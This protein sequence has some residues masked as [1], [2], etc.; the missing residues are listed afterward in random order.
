M[1]GVQLELGKRINAIRHNPNKKLTILMPELLKMKSGI[2][3][4]MAVSDPLEGIVDFFNAVNPVFDRVREITETIDAFDAANYGDRHKQLLKQLT[5]LRTHVRNAG[6]DRSGMNRTKTGELT[7]AHT[8]FL[9]DIW[10]LFT[11]TAFYWK[12][13][14]E[15]GTKCGNG[16]TASENIRL[17]AKNFM[18][19]H[20]PMVEIINQLKS[21]TR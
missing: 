19:S 18:Q 16:L 15:D 12:T 11:L 5:L 6:R 10:G 4:A 21:V 20:L 1:F 7:T 2:Q 13:T 3:D 17:Q 8:V 9:G 14:P